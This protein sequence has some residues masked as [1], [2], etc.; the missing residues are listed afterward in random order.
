MF[1][2]LFFSSLSFPVCASAS[3]DVYRRRHCILDVYRRQ[4][5][6]LHTAAVSVQGYTA[7]ALLTLSHGQG[8]APLLPTRCISQNVPSSK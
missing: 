2:S 5:S 7:S 1:E 4:Y 3:L 6:R 8:R